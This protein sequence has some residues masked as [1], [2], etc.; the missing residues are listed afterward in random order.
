MRTTIKTMT[1]LGLLIIVTVGMPSCK[2]EK[3]QQIP[4]TMSFK[5]TTGYTSADA[6]LPKN[7]TITVGITAAKSED[8]DLLTRFVVAQKYDAASP[9][10]IINESFN[11][12]TYSKD[13][14]IITRNI[15]GIETYTYTIINRDGLTKTL[16]LTLTVN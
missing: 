1:I 10:T 6:I 16:T 8:K 4:P 5:T 2:K 15:S 9:T 7:D 12:D 3:D 14:K 11:Q 13:M